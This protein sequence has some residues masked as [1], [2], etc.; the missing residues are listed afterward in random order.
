MTPLNYTPIRLRN[1]ADKIIEKRYGPNLIRVT[2][3]LNLWNESTHSVT[4]FYPIARL[5]SVGDVLIGKWGVQL[6]S[7]VGPPS[8]TNWRSGSLPICESGII[9]IALRFDRRWPR[10]ERR[11]K[12]QRPQSGSPVNAPLSALNLAT[13]TLTCDMHYSAQ[14]LRKLQHAF[15]YNTTS[16]NDFLYF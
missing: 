11:R 15:I 6:L 4:C 7:G 16:V 12:W 2:G 14:S 3:L 9:V 10:Q 5:A 13:V 8:P 1:F